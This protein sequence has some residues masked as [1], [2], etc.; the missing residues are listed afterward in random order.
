MT[1]PS[2]VEEAAK[3]EKKK[4]REKTKRLTE[5][6]DLCI[7]GLGDSHLSTSILASITVQLLTRR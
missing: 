1:Y 4:E 6:R 3:G 2:E 7:Q 5:A